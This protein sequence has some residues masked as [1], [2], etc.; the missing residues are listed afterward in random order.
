M[1][2]YLHASIHASSRYSTKYSRAQQK[3]VLVKRKEKKSYPYVR[4]MLEAMVVQRRSVTLSASVPRSASYVNP[5]S[6]PTAEGKAL[7][8]AERAAHSRF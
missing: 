7:L 2:T 5:S 1:H 8:L 4:G 3:Q 6:T